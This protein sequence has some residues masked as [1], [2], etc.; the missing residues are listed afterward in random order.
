MPIIPPYP[1]LSDT[2]PA[3]TAQQPPNPYFL[4][5]ACFAPDSGHNCSIQ[6]S[7]FHSNL[8][9]PSVEAVCF[10]VEGGQAG[11]IEAS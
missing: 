11:S 3:P 9:L 4:A 2:T 5:S 6:L 10:L 1:L 8:P 7:L